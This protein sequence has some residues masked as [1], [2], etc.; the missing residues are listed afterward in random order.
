MDASTARDSHLVEIMHSPPQSP[1]LRPAD[2]P[3]S[4][5]A[6]ALVE[7]VLVGV[8][9]SSHSS[10]VKSGAIPTSLD[11]IRKLPE[12]TNKSTDANFAQN[13]LSVT[14]P[15]QVWWDDGDSDLITAIRAQTS[16][17]I[18][19][20]PTVCQLLT[21]ISRRLHGT[22]AF[23]FLSRTSLLTRRD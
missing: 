5:V 10:P 15:Q 13:H 11:E 2:P 20:Y 16:L 22:A 17:E 9:C 12:A 1:V 4:P 18:N 6:S 23:N 14:P 7:T 8:S 19:M 21:R 3:L